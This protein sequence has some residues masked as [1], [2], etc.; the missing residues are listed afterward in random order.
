MPVNIKKENVLNDK[1][2][3]VKQKIMEQLVSIIPETLMQHHELFEDGQHAADLMI[4]CL[5]M[6]MRDS[7]ANFFYSSN[8][9]GNHEEVMNS[10]FN[11]IKNEVNIVLSTLMRIE[12]MPTSKIH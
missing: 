6:F 1:Q 4:S 11:T 7:L 9:R 2:K 8:V 5:I 10:L 12:D 3:E